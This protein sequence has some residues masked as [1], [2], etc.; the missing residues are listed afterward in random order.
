MAL[1][2]SIVTPSFNQAQFLEATIRS[3][4]GQDYPYL[5][6]LVMDGGSTDGSAE[7]MRKYSGRL[8]YWCSEADGGQA[9]AIGKGFERST[10]DVLCWLNSDDL[11]LP[12]ALSK[13]ARHFALHPGV[14]A[15]SGGAYCI[16]PE[17]RPLGGPGAYTLGVGAT[18]DRLRFYEQDGVFQPATFW[19]RSAYEAVGGIDRSLRFIMDRDL[20]AR[21]A[22]RRPFARLPELLA[23]FRV[24]PE[25]K[26][27]RW[28][29]VRREE[30]ALFRRR[31]GVNRWPAPLRRLL[32]WRYRLPSLAV[33][34]WRWSRRTLGAAE[35]PGWHNPL[36][37]GS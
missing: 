12:G 14:E 36:E 34:A 28:Q 15:I 16:G 24:H 2:I 27:A 31:F 25:A 20:F 18:F 6:Y 33:K 9:D 22:R 1:R 4:L 35:L 29:H 3:V 21:L 11:Y 32:Y 19:R 7:I 5:E 23:C 8:A 17:G 30:V 26:T 37:A 10:G 13:V